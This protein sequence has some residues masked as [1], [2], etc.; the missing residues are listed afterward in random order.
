[1]SH[2]LELHAPWRQVGT[3]VYDA[4]DARVAMVGQASRTL[5]DAKHLGRLIAAAP[6]LL[7]ACQR[8]AADGY[9]TALGDLEFIRAAI[10]KATGGG[11]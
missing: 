1:M 8:I 4:A 5:D 7:E 9:G 10:A 6:E 3:S 11:E 2:T